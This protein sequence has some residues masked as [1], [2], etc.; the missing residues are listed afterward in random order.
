MPK[1]TVLKVIEEIKT[2]TPAEQEQVRE[3]LAQ[4]PTATV[5]TDEEKR[6][7]LFEELYRDGLI[8]KMPEH[9]R[10][11]AAFDNYTPV[12]IQGKPLSETVIEDRR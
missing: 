12:P 9:A 2:L 1:V 10:D 6:Q 7:R 4:L 3:V 8:D 11:R 5:S